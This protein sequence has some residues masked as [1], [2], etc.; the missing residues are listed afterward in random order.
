MKI[1]YF[2]SFIIHF[3]TSNLTAQVSYSLADSTFKKAR[4]NY[5]IIP[6]LFKSIETKWA[7]GISGSVSFK[8][9]HKTDTLT[10]TSTIQGIAMLTQRHQNIQALDATIYFPKEDYIFYLQSS[11]SYFPDKFWGLGSTTKNIKHEDYE[12]RQFYILTQLKKKIR[13]NVFTGL[14]FEYQNV[15]D[16][17]YI[18]NKLFD[19]FVL[20][21]KENHIVSGLGASISFDNRNSSY[22]PTKGM[23]L[24]LTYRAAVKSLMNSNYTNLKTIVDVRYFV[25][26]YNTTIFAAQLYTL[27][28]FQQSPIRELA[29]LGGAYNLRGFYQGRFRDEKMTT[30]I[31]EYRLPVYKR[32]SACFFYGVGCV[33]KNTNDIFINSLKS[34]YGAGI[35]ISILPK[36]K[37]NVRIDYGYSDKYNKGLYFT[38]GECF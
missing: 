8:T 17:Q 19:T 22:W 24:Q 20:Y 5:L 31:G 21:G 2:F 4:R 6:I 25:K 32:F 18:K 26:V 27:L 36:E 23:L 13:K 34:S 37:L 15:Y 33:Y 28:N 7:L 3:F 29:M 38:I 10:R 12:Y 30:F 1:I 14:M 16:I 9:T 11:H 35:R